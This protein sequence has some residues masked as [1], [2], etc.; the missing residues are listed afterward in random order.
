MSDFRLL[1]VVINYK[2]SELVCDALK[3]LEGE[4]NSITDH[5]VVVDNDSQDNSV[6]N[7]SN[8]IQLN[9]WDGWV[10]VVNS[11]VNGGF[12]A[13]NNV[14]IKFADAGY[15]LL[16]NSDAYV[17]EGAIQS[18]IT[19]AEA[20]PSVGLLGPKLEW[21]DGRQQVSCFYNLSPMNSFLDSTKMSIFTR[22]LSYFGV[23]E[24][25]ISLDQHQIERLEWLSFACVLLRGR[26]V[27]D[28]GL[29]DEGYFMY[30]ED[31]D[32]CRRATEAGWAL[33]FEPKS[34][35][36]HLN[37]GASNKMG[38]KRLPTYYFRSRSR[39]FIKYYG[40]LGL[41]LANVFWSFGRCISLLRELIQRKPKTFHS[42][43]LF[44]IWVGFL[45]QVRENEE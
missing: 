25:A 20:N 40:R 23:K 30:R 5:V 6:E 33:V 35:V 22:F 27:K 10:S 21:P 34:K 26:M 2:T 17:R 32:Y 36:V 28:I 3:S 43:M 42:T 8:F 39:Y 31:N 4:L 14:G 12:S 41:L 19:T 16:L 45:T 11:E 15:Y 24:I 9:N 38:L 37:K 44:D 1:V 7:I 18:L 13:G 29:M